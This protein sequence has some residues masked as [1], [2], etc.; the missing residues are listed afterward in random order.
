MRKLV[1]SICLLAFVALSSCEKVDGK[2]E[3]VVTPPNT[4]EEDDREL[5]GATVVCAMVDPLEKVLREQKQFTEVR[6]PL[7][8]A[9]GETASFQFVVRSG[10]PLMDLK[11]EAGD[12]SCGTCSIPAEFTAF[13]GYVGVDP[14][15]FSKI[16]SKDKIISGSSYYPDPLIERETVNVSASDNQPIWISYRIPKDAEAGTYSAEVTI[17]GRKNGA[18]FRIR[19]KVSAEVWPVT[20]PDQTLLVYEWINGHLEYLNGGVQPEGERYW[21]LLKLVVNKARDYGHN[22]YM[23]C[24]INDCKFTKDGT[25]YSGPDTK[26][27]FDWTD[28]DRR[29]EVMLREGGAKRLV[30]QHFAYREWMPGVDAWYEPFKLQIPYSETVTRPFDD[31]AKNFLDQFFPALY[32]HLK[33]KGWADIYWQHIGDEPGTRENAESYNA[34][35]AYIKNLVP[36]LRVLEANHSTKDVCGSI[37]VIAP[38]LDYFHRD[39]S[40]YKSQQDA[41]KELW[42]YTCMEPVGDY[43][44]R[45]VEL[46]LIQTRILHWINFRYGA[47]GYLCWG[48]DSWRTQDWENSRIDWGGTPAGDSWIIWP[49][50]D[51]VYSSLRLEAMRDG[52]NDYELLKLLQMKE[53][54]L[55]EETA[56]G[57]VKD[58]NS[59]DSRISAFRARRVKILEA[60]SK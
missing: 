14:A 4:E 53:P 20:V 32:A 37:D 7:D 26:Y 42:F 33:E 56:S 3:P 17:T 43:A 57:V 40:F 60:L 1:H 29:V 16:P 59:Y 28:F 54:A 15:S 49:S 38:M 31:T 22:V 47:T 58:F 52:I 21:E 51:K 48:L 35:A 8:V 13:V 2:N 45:F 36:E 10:Q 27:G 24:P 18:D 55:A 46:P 11:V 41:G 25:G 5:I 6:G 50:Y 12:L 19:K 9:K 34:I 23:V 44:N 30:G 39:Y